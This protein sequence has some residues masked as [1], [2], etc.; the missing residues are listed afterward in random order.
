MYDVPCVEVVHPLGNLDKVTRNSYE[1]KLVRL[2]L[3]SFLSYSNKCSIRL[4]PHL[5]HLIS[6]VTY[7][8][9]KKLDCYITQG[10]EGLAGTDTL[11]Y[12]THL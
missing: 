3:I 11:S 12:Y 7:D 8:W 10:W 9:P 5:Q 4:W 6:F 2:Y 1:R